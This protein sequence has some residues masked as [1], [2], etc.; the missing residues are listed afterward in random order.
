MKKA[1]LYLA[2]ALMLSS[3]SCSINAQQDSNGT[4]KSFP[5]IFGSKG[6]GLP[7]KLKIQGIIMEVR[8]HPIACG[9]IATAGTIKVKLTGKIKGYDYDNVFLVL[10]CFVGSSAETK[11]LN[12]FVSISVD[13][14]YRIGKPCYYE[15][16]ANQIDSQGAPFYCFKGWYNILERSVQSAKIK[17]Q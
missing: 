6:D 3:I 8:P 15:A 5:V 14:F 12:K 13:K 4:P 11:Y 17:R 2:A 16:I 10:P 7:G 9:V 1:L